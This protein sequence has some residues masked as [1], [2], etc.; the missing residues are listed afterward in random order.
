MV[1]STM[2]W[3]G[4]VDLRVASKVLTDCPP[5][6]TI[7]RSPPCPALALGAPDSIGLKSSR[8]VNPGIAG[9]AGHSWRD[10]GRLPHKTHL[11]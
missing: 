9:P 2:S 3:A 11:R 7:S 8:I 1:S 5:A 6:R 10:L 4:S